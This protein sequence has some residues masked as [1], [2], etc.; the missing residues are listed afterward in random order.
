MDWK[1]KKA[2]IMDFDGT[3]VDSMGMW[4]EIDA[5]LLRDQ[6]LEVPENLLQILTPLNQEQTEQY[7]IRLGC[8]GDAAAIRADIERRAGEAYA[9]RIAAK[10]G[11][12]AFVE[13]ARALGI[14]VGIL[15]AASLAQVLPSLSHNDMTG[16]FSLIL[17]CGA[18]GLDKTSPEIY[19]M[20][21]ETLGVKP[22]DILYFDDN[23]TA[24]R[25]AKAAGFSTVGVYD[26]A[27]DAMWADVMND[28]D[29]FIRSFEELGGDE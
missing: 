16:W 20:A 1:N 18:Y 28:A 22:G 2:I 10:P 23:L 24:L 7:F 14:P 29:D 26:A 25:A 21:S 13:R 6:G 27:S 15:T 9:E 11:A 12:R 8:R 3:L 5:A 4:E 19:R 17:S